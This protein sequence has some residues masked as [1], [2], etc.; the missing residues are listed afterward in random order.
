MVVGLVW[1]NKSSIKSYFDVNRMPRKSNRNN[2]GGIYNGKRI[3][4]KKTK[5]AY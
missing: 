2:L 1:R 5:S 3:D 4:Y